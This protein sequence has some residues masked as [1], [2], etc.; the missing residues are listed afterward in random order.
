VTASESE[1]K[2][3]RVGDVLG[4]ENKEVRHNLTVNMKEKIIDIKVNA[5][6]LFVLTTA[7]II[8]YKIY[9][10]SKELVF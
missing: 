9:N 2:V 5:Q 3:W 10:L 8:V 6:R 1:V 4:D 7:G